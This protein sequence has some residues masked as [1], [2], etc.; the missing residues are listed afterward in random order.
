MTVSTGCSL[1]IKLERHDATMTEIIRIPFE[2][3]K[4]EFADCKFS[5]GCNS[6]IHC[7]VR[8]VTAGNAIVVNLVSR[9]G[10]FIDAN[11]GMRFAHDC[12][13]IKKGLQNALT[14]SANP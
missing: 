2:H 9:D 1:I 13:R 7:A 8:R 11:D 14:C 3:M 5:G 12:E 6:P 4:K 10:Y